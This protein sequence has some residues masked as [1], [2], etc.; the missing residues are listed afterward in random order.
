MLGCSKVVPR[1]RLR[2]QQGSIPCL[3]IMNIL[4]DKLYIDFYDTK[5]NAN[6]FDL[7]TYAN[8]EYFQKMNMGIS[9]FK[10]PKTLQTF[11]WKPK[12]GRLEVFRGEYHKLM[13]VDPTL[14]FEEQFKSFPVNL[15]YINTDFDFDDFQKGAIDAVMSRRQGIVH[16]VTSAGKSLMILKAGI[17]LKQRMLIVVHR[18]I[19]MEQFIEDIEKYVRDEHG[20]KITIGIIGSGKKTIGDITIAIDKTLAKNLDEYKDVFGTVFMDECHLAP[21]STMLTVIN[22]LR[23]ERRYG[24]S[25]TLKRKDQKEFLM[26]GTFGQVI[27]EIRR[28]Q[29]EEKGRVVKVESNIIVS[30]TLFDYQ[31]TISAIGITRASQVMEKALAYDPGRMDLILA[32]VAKMPGKTIVLSKLVEPCYILQKMLM[33]QYG[34]KSGVITGRDAKSSLVA[35]EEMK[36]QDLKVIFATV[37]CVSTGVSIS[38]LNNL[39]LIAPIYTNELLLHQIRGRLM[40]T[41]KGK[42]HGDFYFVYDQHVFPRSR[43]DRLLA[44]LKK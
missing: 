9:V 3:L 15:Q 4:S 33:E 25:G 28:E 31:G 36:H 11:T 32:K 16:A 43:L 19:L 38:D 17:D 34:I 21:T 39:V 20:N 41:A 37:G 12:E 44:I 35:Y 42:T 24:F 27:Y 23:C 7:L 40:R 10:V 18:K 6:V 1:G 13:M 8:P 26:Y 29:L 14:R 22:A 2:H 5:L 30:D